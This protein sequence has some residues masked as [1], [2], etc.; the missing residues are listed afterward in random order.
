MQQWAVLSFTE[1][2]NSVSA[3]PVEKTVLVCRPWSWL[4]SS[5]CTAAPLLHDAC[6]SA[7]VETVDAIH[8]A[9]CQSYNCRD[10][11][12]L[13]FWSWEGCQLHGFGSVDS[14]VNGI[15]ATD[16]HRHGFP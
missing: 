1:H 9:D 5:I 14:A 6:L 10:A 2:P 15:D 3:S 16:H 7:A 13:C 8:I 11:R 4:S 12:E